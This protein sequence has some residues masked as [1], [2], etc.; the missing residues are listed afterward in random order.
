MMLSWQYSC[1]SKITH[2]PSQ[3]GQT[4]LV[5]GLWSEFTCRSVC[6]GLHVSV[7]SGCNLCHPG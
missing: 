1:M 7:C 2:K 5:F 6:T 4:D 3:L